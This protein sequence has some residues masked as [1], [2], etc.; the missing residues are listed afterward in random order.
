MKEVQAWKDKVLRKYLLTNP[1][2]P[3][4]SIHLDDWFASPEARRYLPR[5]MRYTVPMVMAFTKQW[6]KHQSSANS[7][8]EEPDDTE[9]VLELENNYSWVKLKTKPAFERE[10]SLMKHCVRTYFNRGNSIIFSL[11]DKENHP[12][13]T[14]EMV[15]R[16]KVR[17]E[18]SQNSFIIMDSIGGMSRR[19]AAP[20]QESNPDVYFQINQISGKGNTPLK[21]KY[22]EALKSFLQFSKNNF[23]DLI[24]TDCLKHGIY[25]AGTAPELFKNITTYEGNLHLYSSQLSFPPEL[26]V[27]GNVYLSNFLGTYPKKLMVHKDCDLTSLR[28]LPEELTLE[29]TGTLAVKK[30]Q[31]VPAHWTYA[32]LDRREN[33]HFTFSLGDV[34]YNFSF[35]GF[36]ERMHQQSRS[37]VNRTPRVGTT[38]WLE[39][40]L[41]GLDNTFNRLARKKLAVVKSNFPS[42]VNT[43]RNQP[44]L[45]KL[46][47][48]F[49]EPTAKRAD[50]LTRK[51]ALVEQ[52]LLSPNAIYELLNQEEP[53]ESPTVLQLPTT[54]PRW[55]QNNK[56]KEPAFLNPRR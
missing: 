50:F 20:R 56:K 1:V 18:R 9:V 17:G 44:T 36:H 27:T 28:S 52:N 49:T 29:V 35:T 38:I 33:N 15:K 16:G 22:Q 26:T 31:Q 34:G 45:D 12:H 42:L 23:S 14:V 48:A 10:S 30:D 43:A 19:E 8:L 13:C 41:S 55:K 3:E 37:R 6:N 21:E 54:T 32:R 11:R 25:S 47:G 53:K 7:L 5:L 40:D 46:A 39:Q 51:D 4:E 24:I 2:A